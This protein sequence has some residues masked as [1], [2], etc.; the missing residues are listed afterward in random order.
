MSIVMKFGGTSVQDAAAMRNV[1][2]IVGRERERLPLIVVSA[3]AGVTNILVRLAHNAAAGKA[4]SALEEFHLLEARHLQVAEELFDE[5]S[6]QDVCCEVSRIFREIESMIPCVA[7]L[8]ELTPRT[9]DQFMSCGERCSSLLLFRHLQDCGIDTNL[10]DARKVLITDD[11]FGNAAPHFKIVKR[12]ARRFILPLLKNGRVVV[13]QG[14][15]GSTHSS[16]T[17]T[18]G[19]GGSDYSA[20]IFGSVLEVEEIQIWTDVEGILTADPSILPEARSIPEMTFEEAAELAYFGARVL[21]P[22]TIL[23]AVRKNIPVRVLNS[24]EPLSRGTMITQ[25]AQP[26]VSA[27]KSI[28]YKEDITVVRI[29]NPEMLMG[30][31][32]LARLFEVFA[33]HKKCVDL[34]AT[35]MVGI[36]MT[37]RDEI[38][39]DEILSEFGDAADI[40]VERGRAICSI[41]GERVKITKGIAARVF[42]A[43]DRAG[44]NVEMISHG[45][46]DINLSFVIRQSDVETAVR[47]LHHEFFTN[48]SPEEKPSLTASP[49]FL[50]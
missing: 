44:V 6:R 11:A 10:V 39:L 17:T 5:S 19:R 45:G 37:V 12:Q 24:R 8:Q 30:H 3:C 40:C 25:K 29:Q 38:A 16:V 48:R 27:V 4:A 28:A 50:G 22:S 49:A 7:T 18:L 42:S 41:V 47:S 26:S 35:S 20:A 23:P 13:T 1:A 9:L 14:F 21:H 46:S 31:Q 2:A 15:I 36:S 32:F 33:R 43:L 34:I